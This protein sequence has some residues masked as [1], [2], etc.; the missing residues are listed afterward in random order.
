MSRVT[1]PSTAQDNP[2]SDAEGPDSGARPAFL[3]VSG[4]TVAF[5]ATFFIPVVLARVFSRSEFGTYKQLFLIYSTFYLIAP[6]GMAESLFY[7]LPSAPQ[8][9][10]RYVANSIWFLA[11]TGSCSIA[12]IVGGRWKLSGWLSNADLA[13]YSTWIGLVLMLMMISSVLEITMIA[14]RRYGLASSSY[15]ASDILRAGCL[16]VPAMVWRSLDALLIGA[17]AFAALRA[18]AAIFYLSRAFDGDFR[19]DFTILRRQLAYALSFGVAV[20][21]GVC[22][23]NLHQYVVSHEFDAATFAIYS[24]GCLQVPF[25]DFVMTSASSVMMVR[26]TEDLRHNRFHHLLHVWHEA[27]RHLALILVPLVG[28]LLVTSDRFIVL[29][30]TERY[31]ESVPVFRL[32]SL[33]ILLA[34]LMTDAALRVYAE[35]RFLLLIN[36]IQLAFVALLLPWA[37]GAFHLSGAVFITLAAAVLGKAL[38]LGRVA[39]RMDVSLSA[40]LPW[41]PLG[42]IAAAAAS[43]AVAA[44]LVVLSDWLPALPTLI[45]QGATYGGVYVM[46]IWRSDWLTD[47][48]RLAVTIRWQR[49][50]GQLRLAVLGQ[51][52][53]ADRG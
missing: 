13:R 18:I 24:V 35:T 44:R 53:T 34:P 50:A 15:G 16:V 29:L 9:E 22:Q 49:M 40:L 41:R 1:P 43:A 30:F 20:V 8:H 10:G 38:A 42:G 12:L 21:V 51:S 2:P 46:L 14:R 4:R 17:V 6:F 23:A 36:V 27:T 45:V 39:R 47:R 52:A 19:P 3:L 11:L 33:A 28:L 31:A 26:M 5:A 7:F 48:E 25:V 37:I 32:W